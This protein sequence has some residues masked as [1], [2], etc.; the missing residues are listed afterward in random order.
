MLPLHYTQAKYCRPDSNRQP[1]AYK[2]GTLTFELRQHSPDGPVRTDDLGIPNAACFHCI[3]SGQSTA[4][5][6]RTGSRRLI[7]PELWSAA[8]IG[9]TAHRADRLF[10]LTSS[11]TKYL[12]LAVVRDSPF[13]LRQQKKT[14]HSRR[15]GRKKR[16]QSLLYH[17]SLFP[18]GD[19]VVPYAK[20]HASLIRMRTL[21]IY[22]HWSR[23][24]EQWL[25][26][27]DLLS[28]VFA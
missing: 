6:T 17:R 2:A 27:A 1:P 16:T 28:H 25:H 7:R 13:E 26:R 11:L 8:S 14:A 23:G 10:R 15:N 3:T 5:L 9:A 22:C 12:P 4:G 21:Y 24:Y 18:P 20:A 19:P